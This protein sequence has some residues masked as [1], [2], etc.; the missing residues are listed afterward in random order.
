M[1]FVKERFGDAGLYPVAVI[2]GLTDMDAIALSTSN[3]AADERLV[4]TTAGKVILVAELSNLAFK[5][6]CAAVVGAAALRSRVALYLG[7]SI[8]GGVA[9][10]FAWP[11]QAIASGL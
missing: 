8:A 2:G 4:A 6:A 5:G 9:I 7:P 11:W 3:L 10:L 1:A